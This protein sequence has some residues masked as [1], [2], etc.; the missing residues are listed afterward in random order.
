MQCPACEREVPLGESLCLAC[1]SPVEVKAPAAPRVATPSSETAA[2]TGAESAKATHCPIHPDMPV[3]GTCARCG[4]FMCI[5]CTRDVLTQQAPLCAACSER[6]AAPPQGIGGWLLLPALYVVLQPLLGLV[7]G[8]LGL[9]VSAT[10]VS[11]DAAMLSGPLLAYGAFATW[12]AV[13]FFRKKASAPGLY[14]AMLVVNVGLA[15]ALD[16][17]PARAVVVAAVWTPYF[18]LSSRVKTTFVR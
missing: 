16:S 12:V 9:W 14:I 10:G 8:A 15:V 18:L 2:P 1:L 13:Q 7:G 11:K 17:D 4:S 5:R 3:A 6:R